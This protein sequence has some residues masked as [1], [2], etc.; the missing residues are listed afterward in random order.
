MDWEVLAKII[1]VISAI[2]TILDKAYTYG[3]PAYAS[4]KKSK[5]HSK[6][7]HKGCDMCFNT[8]TCIT[9]YL[10]HNPAPLKSAGF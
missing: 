5:I 2:V 7:Q 10:K 9:D 4:L 1:A 6:L 3:K 8:V